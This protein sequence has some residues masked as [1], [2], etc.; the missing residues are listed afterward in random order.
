MKCLVNAHEI[1]ISHVFCLYILLSFSRDFFFL[2]TLT[3]LATLYNLQIYILKPFLSVGITIST[4]TLQSPW[5]HSKCLILPESVVL[6]SLFLLMRSSSPILDLASPL[7][8]LPHSW[9]LELVSHQYLYFL[10]PFSPCSFPTAT[11]LAYHHP[12]GLFN[13]V[14]ISSSIASFMK[15]S[16][17]TNLLV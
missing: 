7:T 17:Q 14:L 3:V 16:F 15:S 4:H 5:T 2:P 12:K 13:V 6:V 8:N 11:I 10:K 9:I 1:L